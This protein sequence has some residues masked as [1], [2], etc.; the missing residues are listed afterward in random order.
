MHVLCGVYDADR[1]TYICG[2]IV[3]KT[4]Q[5]LEVDIKKREQI[6]M[7]LT[8]TQSTILD[9]SYKEIL[10]EYFVTKEQKINQQAKLDGGEQL[11]KLRKSIYKEIND[12]LK[13]VMIIKGRQIRLQVR[14]LKK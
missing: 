5:V 1:D 4:L 13:S 9:E 3:D 10:R 7:L 14:E 6:A 2:C 8:I 11:V 12:N